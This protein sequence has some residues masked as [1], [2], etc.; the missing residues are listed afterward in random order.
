[1]KRYKEENKVMDNE[2]ELRKVMQSGGQMR[3]DWEWWTEWRS[4]EKRK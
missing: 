1:M 2:R 3:G 4:D